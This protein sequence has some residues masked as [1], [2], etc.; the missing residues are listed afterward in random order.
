ME[1]EEAL[2]ESEAEI[3]SL[4]FR[5]RQNVSATKSSRHKKTPAATNKAPE[6]A[7]RPRRHPGERR[8]RRDPVGEKVN[9]AD[10]K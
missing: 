10:R 4:R 3:E 6:G 1:G 5:L 9:A 2:R 8:P 7:D